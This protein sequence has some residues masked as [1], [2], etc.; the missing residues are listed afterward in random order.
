MAIIVEGSLYG[1]Y[2]KR[3]ETSWSP[4][5]YRHIPS[6]YYYQWFRCE[7]DTRMYYSN[8]GVA[9]WNA[10]VIGGKYRQ[11]GE[12]QN[13]AF[14]SFQK[15][16]GDKAGLL[17]NLV[18]GKQAIDMIASRSLQL[19]AAVRAA[20]RLDPK[21][22]ARA[23]G[24]KPKSKTKAKDSAGMWLEYTFGWVPLITDIGTAVDVLQG[25]APNPVV[26]GRGTVYA[27]V[28]FAEYNSR[29]SSTRYNLN[30]GTLST[31]IR[32]QYVARILID[33]PDLYLANQLG[34][35]NP[36]Q[37]LW[38]AVPFSFVVDWFLPVNRFL[39]NLSYDVGLEVKDKG[40]T[41]TVFAMSQG[42]LVNR[43]D[44]IGKYDVYPDNTQQ[45]EM[46]RV[47]SIPL[48]PLQPRIPK[49][50]AWLAVTSLS[51]LIQQLRASSR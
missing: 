7:S 6:P 23:L 9:L 40:Y 43:W 29:V 3:R 24:V 30:E 45:F 11:L 44:A 42:V 2:Y 1:T 13:K 33:N 49:A 31:R 34:F 4:P 27:E 48:P 19:L 22:L 15:Q 18:Q 12:A 36:A 10:Q 5:G 41:F 14:S 17:I 16:L 28:P 35:V 25:P 46:R 21:G 26:K 51:L 8:N 39:G 37:V 38:D 47:N 50:S 20:K 32:C